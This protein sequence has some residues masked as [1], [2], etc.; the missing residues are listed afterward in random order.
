MTT[1]CLKFPRL[2]TPTQAAIEHYKLFHPDF[3]KSL[4]GED[5]LQL[6]LAC[7]SEHNRLEA[8]AYEKQKNDSNWSSKHPGAEPFPDNATMWERA[9]AAVEEEKR[10]AEQKM[11][12]EGED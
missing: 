6:D 8:E 9:T 3:V 2:G 11:E 7:L 12:Q 5:L 1:L 4:T 10:R